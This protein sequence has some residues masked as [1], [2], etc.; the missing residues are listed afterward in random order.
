MDF[1]KTEIARGGEKIT[2]TAKEFKI[3]EFLTKNAER[4]ISR[5][6]LLAK[7]WGYQDY[8][9][10]GR[11]NHML[12]LQQKLES[13]LSHPSHLLTVHGLGYKFVPK[14]LCRVT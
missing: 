10:R 3:L 9:A 6:E 11:Y 13:D 1:L 5:D 2:V 4:T 8:P 7:V 12:R 14:P